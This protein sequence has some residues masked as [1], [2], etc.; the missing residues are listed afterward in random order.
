MASAHY[1]LSKTFIY[2][3]YNAL[4]SLMVMSDKGNCC[5][6]TFI[7]LI[8]ISLQL[9][10]VNTTF[11]I[12]LYYFGWTL[13]STS[14]TLISAHILQCIIHTCNMHKGY[15]EIHVVKLISCVLNIYFKAIASHVWYFTLSHQ[16]LRGFHIQ[17][18]ITRTSVFTFY[19]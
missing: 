15:K 18:L 4:T 13:N 12:R 8:Q 14:V 7:L 16:L 9:S 19:V 17:P 5:D 6:T 1:K 11:N 3:M 10:H 2:N